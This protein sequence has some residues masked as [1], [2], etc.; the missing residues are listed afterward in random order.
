MLAL[1]LVPSFTP[2]AS[3]RS[4]LDPAADFS[5]VRSYAWM[6]RPIEVPD[7]ERTAPILDRLL[8]E[9]VAEEFELRGIEPALEGQA[10]L[11]FIYYIDPRD[12]L[13]EY[14][15][16][17]IAEDMA[18]WL[19]PLKVYKESMSVVVMDCINRED[20]R[21]VWRGVFAMKLADPWKL[22]KKIRQVT[23]GLL[24]GIPIPKH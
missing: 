19:R 2:A 5:F 16:E 18:G 1:L 12:N 21:L 7:V 15:R 22:A 23:V 13:A 9:T 10:D 8:H 24:R 11:L 20:G 4:D 3:S 6:T 17:Y 14:S